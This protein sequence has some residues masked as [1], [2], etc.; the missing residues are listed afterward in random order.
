MTITRQS[1]SSC[2]C[3]R[4]S[5]ASCSCQRSRSFLHRP[6]EAAGSTVDEVAQGFQPFKVELSG[7]S[8]EAVIEQACERM[9]GEPSF[10]WRRGVPQLLRP[11]LFVEGT[12]QHAL[13]PRSLERPAANR[14]PVSQVDGAAWPRNR[15]RFRH[16]WP[17]VSCAAS[18]RPSSSRRAS[19][20]R[21]R[22]AERRMRQRRRGSRA[23]APQEFRVLYAAHRLT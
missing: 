9:G 1:R 11:F 3:S 4:V 21:T 23:G 17:K 8:D 19:S 22:R 10:V 6:P 20:A 18:S 15:S 14:D 13:A 5:A 12:R 16:A 2:P 7:G